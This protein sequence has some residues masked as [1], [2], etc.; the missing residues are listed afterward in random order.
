V[1]RV[2]ESSS[3][4]VNSL[5]WREVRPVR[6]IVTTIVAAAGGFLLFV[7]N[8]FA[9]HN[10]DHRTFSSGVDWGSVAIWTGIGVGIVLLAT[11][12]VVEGRRHHW[13]PPHRPVHTN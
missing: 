9:M 2:V 11:W 13:V 12:L 5:T 6:R 1:R 3:V 7:P 10:L 8:A 4:N